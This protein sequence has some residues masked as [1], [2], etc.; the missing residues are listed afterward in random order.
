MECEAE[1]IDGSYTYCGCQDCDQREYDDIESDVEY[2]AITEAEA[3][4]LHRLN[5]AL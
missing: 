4:N 2:G 5:G 1:F 3:L